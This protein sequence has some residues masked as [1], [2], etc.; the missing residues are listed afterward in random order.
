MQEIGKPAWKWPMQA[1]LQPMQARISSAR[2]VA[3][4]I[5]R[6]GSQMSARVIATASACPAA[7]MCSASCGWFTRPATMTGTRTTCFVAAAS[8]AVYAFAIAIDGTMWSEP[9]SVAELP[10][11]TLT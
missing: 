7:M 5:G 1:W 10:A 9:P 6:S 8:G 11:T 2:P 4:L 3:A